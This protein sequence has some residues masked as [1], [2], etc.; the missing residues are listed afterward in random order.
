MTIIGERR[1]VAD[2]TT[3]NK[4]ERFVEGLKN[5]GYFGSSEMGPC[6][7]VFGTIEVP[8]EIAAAIIS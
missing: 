1:K 8:Q 6:V 5:K 2:F 7:A 4:V 3:P